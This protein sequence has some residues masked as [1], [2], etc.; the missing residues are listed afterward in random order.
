MNILK[1]G[2]GKRG[3][4]LSGVLLVIVSFTPLLFGRVFSFAPSDVVT[5]TA[6]AEEEFSFTPGNVQTM[7]LPEAAM[8]LKTE[9]AKGIGGGEISVVDGSALASEMGPGGTEADVFVKES[10]PGADKISIYIV[11]EGDSLDEVAEMFG[12]TANTIVWANDLSSKTIKLGQELVIL[13]V[14]GVRHVVKEGET[15]AGVVKKYK[16]DLGE[17][18]RY[19]GIDE[20][21]TLVEGTALMIPNG[22]VVA[23]A[24]KRSTVS[25][26]GGGLIRPARGVRTQGIHGYNG[27]DIAASIGTPVVAAGGGQVIISR[28]G[29][30]N[31]G[32]GN[33][34]VIKHNSGIQTLYAHLNS[35]SVSQGQWVSQGQGIGTMGNSGRSTGPHLHFE[36]RGAPN[37]F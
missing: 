31:G 11:R 26:G 10:T 7:K 33:Y 4:T 19:N 25:S 9:S 8:S 2:Q 27:I 28:A 35:I 23:P 13:P 14:V 12:V 6:F 37:P 17:V 16:A 18:A 32:Y 5:E 29:S 20:G 24:P 1:L 36:V 22:E 30:W 3:T 21:E 34:V 15:F